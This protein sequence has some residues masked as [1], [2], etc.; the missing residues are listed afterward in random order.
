MTNQPLGHHRNPIT[1]FATL[2]EVLKPYED[3]G[4]AVQVAFNFSFER[5]TV[6][7]INEATYGAEEFDVTDACYCET[8]EGMRVIPIPQH[9]DYVFNY[10]SVAAFYKETLPR[11]TFIDSFINEI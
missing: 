2:H 10:E 3:D 6:V 7:V 9:D 11:S 1:D 8:I 5:I 4:S